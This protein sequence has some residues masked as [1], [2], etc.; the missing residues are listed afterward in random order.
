MKQDN[1]PSTHPEKRLHLKIA[2]E[3]YTAYQEEGQASAFDV[4][5]KYNVPY[6]YCPACG[7]D[8]PSL[9]HTCLICGQET[10]TQEAALTTDGSTAGNHRMVKEA[11]NRRNA[12][13]AS[14][15]TE[16]EALKQSN[17]LYEDYIEYC[18]HLIEDKVVPKH[19]VEWRDK[20]YPD[21]KKAIA[22]HTKQ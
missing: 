5:N 14:L 15:K 16:N 19:F 8:S 1:T 17:K 20:Y 13:I 21:I 10:G 11:E 22:K 9:K 2:S 4:A 6:E 3:V 12:L 18:D 7:T